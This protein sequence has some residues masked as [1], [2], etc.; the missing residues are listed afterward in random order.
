MTYRTTE[1]RGKDSDEKQTHFRE[2]YM[3]K[4]KKASH[5]IFGLTFSIF[6]SVRFFF[7]TIFV[8]IFPS[9]VIE[10]VYLYFSYAKRNRTSVRRK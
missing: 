5:F 9:H 10:S 6:C 4:H 2:D 8:C 1:K 3:E 7:V